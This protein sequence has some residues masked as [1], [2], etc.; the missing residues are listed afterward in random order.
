MP[1]ATEPGPRRA[2]IAFRAKPIFKFQDI[3]S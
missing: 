3:P 1:A 2:G